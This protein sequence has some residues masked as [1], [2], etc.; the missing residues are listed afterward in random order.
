MLRLS[1]LEEAA[2]ETAGILLVIFLVVAGFG[3]YVYL[4]IYHPEWVGI[5]GK[6]AHKTLGEHVEGSSVDDSDFFAKNTKNDD[7]TKT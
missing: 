7:S 5:T 4:M 1:S 6:E 3:T 2:M